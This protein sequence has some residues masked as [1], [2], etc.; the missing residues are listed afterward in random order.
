MQYKLVSNHP[1]DLAD[2]RV[3]GPGEIFSME[4]EDVPAVEGTGD[5]PGTEAIDRSHN[6]RL[7]EENLVIQ[8][9]GDSSPEDTGKSK[10]K[11]GGDA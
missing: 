8:V 2:G 3:V 1:E 4:T 7:I 11:R 10:S 6:R 9:D 5:E